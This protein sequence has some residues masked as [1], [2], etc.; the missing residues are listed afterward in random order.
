MMGAM[1]RISEWIRCLSQLYMRF[2][3]NGK[4]SAKDGFAPD[5]SDKNR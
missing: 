1:N 5:E 4:V 3:R 2:I